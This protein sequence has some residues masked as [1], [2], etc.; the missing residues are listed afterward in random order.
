MATALPASVQG[1]LTGRVDRLAPTDC[2][3]LQAASVIGRRFDPQLLSVAV[4]ETDVDDRL[5]AMQMLD[6]VH[7]E[8]KSGDYAFKHAQPA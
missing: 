1:L 4:N 6:L 3:L 8:S 7:R 5:V 2:A